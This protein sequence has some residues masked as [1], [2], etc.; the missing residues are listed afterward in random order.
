MKKISVFIQT[1]VVAL[2]GNIY[3]ATA[4]LTVSA[5]V[6]QN[7]SCHGG[8]NGIVTTSVSSGTTPYTYSWTPGGQSNHTATG[9]SAATYSV[10]VTD[11][12]G[13]TGTAAASISQPAALTVTASAKLSAVCAGQSDSLSATASGGT[14]PFSYSWAGAYD[15]ISCPTCAK[16]LCY[17]YGAAYIVTAIYDGNGCSAT[18]SVSVTVHTPP[19]VSISGPLNPVKP[20]HNDT[21]IALAAGATSYAWSNSSTTSSIIVSPSVP[22]TYS[23]TVHNTYGCVDSGKYSIDT[24]SLNNG[25]SNTS[26]IPVK[27]ST[28]LTAYSYSTYDSVMWFSFTPT[29]SNNQIIGYSNYLGL[30][31]PHIHRLTLYNSSLQMIVDEPMPDITGANQIRIDISHLHVGSTYYVRAARTPAHANMAGCNPST[32]GEC[33]PSQRWDFQMAFR[34]VPVFVPKDS[35]NEAPSVSQLYYENRGQISDL[36]NIPRFDVK[37]Y[38]NYTSPAVYASDSNVS[39]VYQRNDTLQRVDM[40]LTGSG[41]Q[42]SQPVYKMEEDSAA[43][44]LNYFLGYVPNGVPE[45]EGYSRLVYKN[46]YQNIDMQVYSNS[47]GTKLYFVCNPGGTGG[48]GNPANIELKFKGANSVSVTS[49]SGIKVVTD[50]GT[51]SFA[52]G[53]AYM[54][55]AGVIKPKSWHANFEVVNSTTVRFHTGTFNTSEPLIIQ[56][57]RAHKTPNSHPPIYN[58]DWSTYVG[59]ADGQDVFNDVCSDASGN[60]YATGYTQSKFYPVTSGAVQDSLKGGLDATLVKFSNSTDSDKRVWATYY[61]GNVGTGAYG[62][63]LD[64]SNNVYITGFT[65][66]TNLPLASRP[67]SPNNYV[68]HSLVPNDTGFSYNAFIAMFTN[69]GKYTRWATYYGGDSS[70]WARH[71]AIDKNNNVYVVGGGVYS[72]VTSNFSLQKS[73]H[74]GAYFDSTY[75]TGFILE[76]NANNPSA[77][78]TREWATRIGDSTRDTIPTTVLY[79]CTVDTSN[80]FYVTGFASGRGYTSPAYLTYSYNVGGGKDAVVSRFD[81]NN[82]VLWSSYFGGSYDDDGRAIVVGPGGN[83]YITGQT[84]SDSSTGYGIQTQQLGS[85]FFQ[86]SNGNL[87]NGNG[88]IAEFGPGGLREWGTYFGGSNSLAGQALAMDKYNNLYV[89]GWDNA[90]NMPLPGS[91]PVGVYNQRTFVSG[92]TS[93]DGFVAAFSSPETNPDYVWGT[94]FGNNEAVGMCIT[95]SNGHN[96]LYIVGNIGNGNTPLVFPPGSWQEDTFYFNNSNSILGTSFISQFDINPIIGPAGIAAINNPVGNML[97]YP[98]PASQMTTLQ[99]NLPESEDVQVSVINLLG[100]TLFTTTYKGEQGIFQQQIPLTS[101]PAA[102][103]IIK[104]Q[105]KDKVY[106]NEMIKLQ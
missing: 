71:I 100:K 73:S 74:A 17:P 24:N 25:N 55:S 33:N 56:V 9:L 84:L 22:I 13:L 44:Y 27:P 59:G 99:L 75:G 66:S 79:G 89:T 41:V 18:S 69:D 60:V 83:I 48:G 61:G 90:S 85:G 92:Q 10:H 28:T 91:N 81:A 6:T 26:A 96:W 29:D 103:Y 1:L 14:L 23:V 87:Y 70:V 3:Y 51:L 8:S 76:F 88:Y 58:L 57:D 38:T 11:V 21:L 4:Q 40:V 82:G 93:Y 98:N 49:D 37:A 97:V 35:G 46:V 102:T 15:D 94:Y 64:K 67:S 106:Y 31:V 16:T 34:T 101:L 43:G 80:N 20:S 45:V 52:P 68:Q 39:F 5:T 47:L 12:H 42:P 2:F 7:V 19:M 36:N 65:Q 54:D 95:K 72:S 104:A 32:H 53:Y 63:A 86:R 78:I 30:P 105:T 50:L 62:V 77:G